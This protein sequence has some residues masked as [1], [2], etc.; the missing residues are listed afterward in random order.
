MNWLPFFAAD[1]LIR[2]PCLPWKVVPLR[3]A[4]YL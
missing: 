4:L 3:S 2:S 1:C